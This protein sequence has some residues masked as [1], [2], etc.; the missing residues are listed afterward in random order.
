M[1]FVSPIDGNRIELNEVPDKV[2]PQ[3][4]LGIE[5]GFELVC[6]FVCASCE[7]EITMIA[8]TFHA[9]GIKADNGAE[10]LVQ[11]GLDTVSLNGEGFKTLV[12]QGEKIKKGTKVIE[13]NIDF[14]KEK[15]IDL[16]NPMVITN[17]SDYKIELIIPFKREK[18][19]Y[20]LLRKGNSI[21]WK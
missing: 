6:P 10:I 15:S 18:Q 9:F 21:Y 17:E 13:V 14:L 19:M 20:C 3:K 2:F 7:G 5:L 12:K 8:P 16:T 1:K 4:L 11:V